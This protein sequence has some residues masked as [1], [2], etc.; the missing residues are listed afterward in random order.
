[1]INLLEKIMDLCPYLEKTLKLGIFDYNSIFTHPKLDKSKTK[2]SS[3]AE[4]L[5]R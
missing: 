5:L 3:N 2:V 4:L 1:M